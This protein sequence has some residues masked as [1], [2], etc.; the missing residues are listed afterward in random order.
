MDEGAGRHAL[1]GEEGKGSRAGKGED[2][3]RR[4]GMRVRGKGRD[5]G[6]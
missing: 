3:V 4:R 5:E 1:P 6:G 2:E